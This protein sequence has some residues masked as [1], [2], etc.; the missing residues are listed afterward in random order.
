MRD[1]KLGKSYSQ[2]TRKYGSKVL[3]LSTF[4][5]TDCFQTGS[6]H[7]PNYIVHGEYE[8]LETQ[9]VGRKTQYSVWYMAS[10]V[11]QKIKRT[12]KAILKYFGWI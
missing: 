8:Q 9:P 5:P 3:E 10:I 1:G 6:S 4:R 2:R 12:I 7:Q 11:S